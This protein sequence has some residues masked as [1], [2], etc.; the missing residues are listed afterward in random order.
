MTERLDLEDLPPVL[1]PADVC[2]IL[3]K[4]VRRP[5][6]AVRALGASGLRVLKIGRDLRVLRKDL[7]AFLAGDASPAE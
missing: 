3:R 2:R 5:C 1:T 4:D 7:E 6:Q